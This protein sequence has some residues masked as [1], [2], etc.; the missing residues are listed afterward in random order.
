MTPLA[1]FTRTHQLLAF[2]VFAYAFSWWAWVW[3]R[4]DPGHADAPILPLGPLLAAG[5]TLALIGGWPAVTT[6]LARIGHWRVG[7]KWYALALLLPPALT[8]TAVGLN[9][10]LG[11]TLSAELAFP[12]WSDLVV[13]FV[14]I[15]LLIGLGEEPAWRGF[16]L[17][18][19]LVGRTALGGS[20]ILGALHAVWHL[21]LLGVEYDAGN[22]L[23]WLM[24]VFCFGIVVTW[25]WLH[26]Q[27]SLLLPMLMHAS[28]NTAAFFWRMFDGGE[29]IALWWLWSGL[30]LVTV[31][32]VVTLTG[33]ALT[34]DRM[35]ALKDNQ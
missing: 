12:N 6:W 24:S 1:S 35:A 2:F 21:P 11:A 20:L 16:A 9:L 34:R 17:P 19:L 23:P 28:N 7:L 14:F 3:Y 25:M 29:Q 18:R 32:A 31:A 15:F 27:G 5:L 33:P 4:L 30:W 13:R 10:W 8:L 26:T 22:I